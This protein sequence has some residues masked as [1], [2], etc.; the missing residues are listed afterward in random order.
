MN[1]AN[2]VFSKMYQQAAQ[3]GNLGGNPNGGN[4]NNGGDPNVVVE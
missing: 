4:D 3:D 2:T 1:V